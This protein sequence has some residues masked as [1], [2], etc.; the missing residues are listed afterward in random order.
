MASIARPKRRR[1]VFVVLASALVVASLGAGVRWLLQQPIFRVQHVSVQGLRHET[2]AEV[3]RVSGLGVHPSML[4]VNA[5]QVRRR[6][7]RF[8]WIDTV[9]L[10]KHWPNTVVVTVSES[11]P[12]AVAFA[13]GHHLQYVDARGHDLG[14]APLTTNL[15]TLSYPLS[16]KAWPYAGVG[17]ASAY[18]AS[19]LPLAFASQVS[20][21]TEDQKGI[22][23]LKMTTPVTFILGPATNLHAKFVAIA[24]VIAHST[25][26]PGDLVDVTVP[27]ELAVTGPAPS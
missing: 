18:V 8:A 25:L 5:S 24:S 19:R 16:T 1:F 6:L 11:T 2:L 21:I 17:R 12:V 3:L 27:D 26:G 14:S 20:V 15:P 13:Q 7:E 23:A 22:L 4:S 9:K 10:E